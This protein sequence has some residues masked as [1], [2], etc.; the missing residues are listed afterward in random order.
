MPVILAFGLTLLENGIT[1]LIVLLG[2][3]FVIKRAVFAALTKF[4]IQYEDAQQSDS[5][6]S[7]TPRTH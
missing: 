3:Y 4:Y 1:F 6:P 7:D 5:P 2:L